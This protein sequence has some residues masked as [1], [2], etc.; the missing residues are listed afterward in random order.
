MV[1]AARRAEPGVLGSED[2]PGFC[3]LAGLGRTAGG[4]RSGFSSAAGRGAG[5]TAAAAGLA[6]WLTAAGLAGA[7]G[8]AG[9]GGAGSALGGGADCLAAGCTCG[10][11]SARSACAPFCSCCCRLCSSC[12]LMSFCRWY[13]SI[14]CSRARRFS[15]ASAR[16]LR[17]RSSS[18]WARGAWDTPEEA[19]GLAGSAAE[20]APAATSAA[21]LDAS[22]SATSAAAAAVT[23]RCEAEPAST[24]AAMRCAASSAG[25]A[26]RGT[27]Q[28]V[29]AIASFAA[30]SSAACCPCFS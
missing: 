2:D 21:P 20:S 17:T 29:H 1:T 19:R 7:A 15:A 8:A 13:C 14:S 24:V 12:C 9:S 16:S 23:P 22:I 27:S 26:E 18:H 5:A 4:A 11:G 10:A 6:A 25:F 3:S 28:S 30:K